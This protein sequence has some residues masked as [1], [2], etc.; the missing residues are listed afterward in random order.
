MRRYNFWIISTFINLT[1]HLVFIYFL[2]SWKRL[3][4]SCLF[5]AFS[6]FHQV[7]Y[8]LLRPYENDALKLVYVLHTY[9]FTNLVFL[10]DPTTSWTFSPTPPHTFT[11]CSNLSIVGGYQS[12]YYKQSILKNYT[13]LPNH[14]SITIDISIYF[15]DYWYNQYFEIFFD[16][17]I[18]YNNSISSSPSAFADLCGGSYYDMILNITLTQPHLSSSFE[19]KFQ[20]LIDLNKDYGVTLSWGLRDLTIY[21]NTSCPALCSSCIGSICN[22]LVKFA[23]QDPITQVITCKPGFF[24]DQIKNMCNLCS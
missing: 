10:S 4:F 1:F 23:A 19:L 8:V 13:N 9:E 18:V 14:D 12:F 2:L 21:L 6:R 22:S 11:S 15:L 5:S 7:K 20:S 24:Y 16:E 17:V 3:L